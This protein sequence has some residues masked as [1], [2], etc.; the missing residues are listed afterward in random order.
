MTEERRHRS[1]L[2][3]IYHFTLSR[4]VQLYSAL[5]NLRLKIIESRF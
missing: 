2:I 3:D 4:H 5:N 1:K